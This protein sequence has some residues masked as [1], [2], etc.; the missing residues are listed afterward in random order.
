MVELKSCSD[1]DDILYVV[2]KIYPNMNSTFSPRS[3][4]RTAL[5]DGHSDILKQGTAK[6]EIE[7]SYYCAKQLMS[8]SDGIIIK[9]YL[10][11]KYGDLSFITPPE[12]NN[13]EFLKIIY[14]LF[15]KNVKRVVNNIITDYP[16]IDYNYLLP[17]SVKSEVLI[18]T[19][20]YD[21]FNILKHMNYKKTS[22]E[23]VN[24]CKMIFDQLSIEC[25]PVF[26]KTNLRFKL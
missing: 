12:F 5:K 21:I 7:C 2:K 3:M 6:V 13:N 23:L 11:E 18:N 16:N 20:F 8:I 25:E 1:V 19:N 24:I 17:M 22:P 26:N 15:L 10:A 14:L 9:S 4:I